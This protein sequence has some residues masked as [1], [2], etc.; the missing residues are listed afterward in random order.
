MH[1]SA[2]V[3]TSIGF[4][5]LAILCLAFADIQILHESSLLLTI[6]KLF[7]F[8]AAVILRHDSLPPGEVQPTD[9]KVVNGIVVS[10]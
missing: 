6:S 3:R 10:L 7:R 5:G 2:A 8:T 9:V 4:F 1:A